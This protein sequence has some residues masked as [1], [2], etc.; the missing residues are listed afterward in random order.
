MTLDEAAASAGRAVTYRQ[1]YPGA[2][3]ED[4]VIVSVRHPYVMVRY[5]GD[6]HAKATVPED[7]EFATTW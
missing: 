7:L 2:P 4:G 6:Q 1:N 5:A 3:I